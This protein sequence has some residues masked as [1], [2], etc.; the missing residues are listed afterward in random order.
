ML[1]AVGTYA[2]RERSD[3][4]GQ[5]QQLD[6]RPGR[7]QARQL[8][9]ALSDGLLCQRR[10][11]N[12]GGYAGE[13]KARGAPHFHDELLIPLATRTPM[14]WDAPYTMLWLFCDDLRLAP[15]SEWRRICLDPKRWLFPPKVGSAIVDDRYPSDRGPRKAV[16]FTWPRG[17]SRCQLFSKRG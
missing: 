17:V 12:H 15:H 14:G 3:R 8:R 13:V 6:F 1:V 11:G 16:H 10:Q 7:R 9:C 5:S 4:Y 2:G